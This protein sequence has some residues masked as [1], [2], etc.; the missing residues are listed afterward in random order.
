MSFK[1]GMEIQHMRKKILR[2]GVVW[3]LLIS[4]ACA[5]L[6]RCLNLEHSQSTTI[7]VEICELVGKLFMN[8]LKMLVVPLITSSIICGVMR[9]GSKS[10]FHRLGLKTFLFYFLSCFVAVTIGLIVVNTLRPGNTEVALA[11]K[12]LGQADRL[13]EHFAGM[14]GTSSCK[15]SEFLLRLL[16]ANILAAAT[17]NTQILGMIV[18]SLL[19][20]FF[21]GRLPENL[22]ETQ[23]ALWE[24]IQQIT[25]NITYIVIAFAPFGVFGLVTPI[26]LNTGLDLI[27]PLLFF[28]GT[29]LF[30]FALYTFGFLY[31]LL[32]FVGKVQPLQ[33]YKA[34]LPVTLMA[35]STASS[36]AALPVAL[37]RIEHESKVSPKTARFTLPLGITINMCGTALYECVVV[38]FIA[39]LY[40]VTQGISFGLWDQITIVL[41]ALLT[42]VGVAG[43]PASG[44]IAITMILSSVGLP[45]ESIGIIWVVERILDMFRTAVNVFND[46]CGTIVIARSEGEKTAYPH[47]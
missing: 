18:F 41:M 46:T 20:G 30:G 9:F 2:W 4:V 43:I 35:F 6:L 8:G 27:K 28:V 12:I 39:Q 16:P 26:L 32:R 14:E 36:A 38:I 29:I 5:C 25:R 13:P 45:I 42:S 22:R 19:F 21:V 37:D 11:S 24:G 44:L 1:D 3:A 7:F 47:I 34:M 23:F 40:Q 10:E 31:L 15:V 17:D 33:H